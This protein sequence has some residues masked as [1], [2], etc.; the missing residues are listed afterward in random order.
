MFEAKLKENLLEQ[1][2]DKF[3]IKLENMELMLAL[4]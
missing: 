2:Y 4:R 3:T 1:A